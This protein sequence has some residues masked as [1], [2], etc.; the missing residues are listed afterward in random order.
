MVR[1]SSLRHRGQAKL[2]CHLLA[3][4]VLFSAGS[5]WT[6][7]KGS[8]AA[9]RAALEALYNAT[10]GA[11]WTDQTNWLSEE[12]L[13][14]WHGVSLSDDG[15]VI[16]L[17]LA[18]NNLVGG[19]PAALGNLSKL[20]ALFLNANT[21]T[22][23]IPSELGDLSELRQLNLQRNA[24]TGGIPAELGNLSK[25][26][27]LQLAFNDL[28]GPIP[29]QLG[30]LGELIILTL[31]S[32]RLTGGIPATF[33]NL[34][35]LPRLSVAFNHGLTGPLPSEL[36][37]AQRLEFL[38]LHGT[39]VCLPTDPTARNWLSG[40]VVASSGLTC[41]SD[42]PEE[43]VIDVA[44]FY[45][46]QARSAAGGKS[47]IEAA[48]DLRL[49]EA[50]QA[51]E[52]SGVNQR[53]ALAVRE[54]V[55]YS[56]AGLPYE[57][58]KRLLDP[59]DGHMDGIY[60]ILDIAGVD[61]VHLIVSDGGVCGLAEPVPRAESAFSLSVVHCDSLVFAHEIGHSMGLSHDRYQECSLGDQRC[62]WNNHYPYSYGYVNQRAFEAGPPASA[63]WH[64]IMAYRT[65]CGR[66]SISPCP[67]LAFFSNP[68]L[69]HQGDPMGKAGEH[70]VPGTD[71]PANAALALS[72][73][74]HSVA[75]FRAAV[76]P[77][78]DQSPAPVGALAM[79]TLAVGDAAVVLE[80]SGAFMDPNN[81]ALTYEAFSSDGDVAAV[82]LS[83]AV[84]TV[85][86]VSA[87]RSTITV[88]ATDAAG[89][90]T[91]AWQ[92]FTVFVNPED[93][94]DYDV[95]D[96]GLIEIATLA[97]LDAVRYDPN[98]IGES[99]ANEFEDQYA[100]AFPQRLFGM[101]CGT[102][103][104]LGYELDA[105]LD[106]DT[107][108][109]GGADSGD[110]FWNGGKGWRPL[111]EYR[112][113]TG[114]G[115]YRVPFDA[116]FEGN[117]HR[118]RN[119]HL[120]GAPNAS[121]IGLFGEVG[122][123]AVIRRVRMIDVDV[124]GRWEVGGLVGNNRGRIVAS[125]ATGSVTA[126][127]SIVGGLVGINLDTIV[128]SWAAV[129]VSG[130]QAVGGL[131]GVNFG[132][133]ER[134]F[135]GG[136]VAGQDGQVGGLVGK[137]Q[138]SVKVSYATGHIGEGQSR[139]GL[140]GM[141]LDIND[142]GE[143]VASYAAARVAGGSALAGGLIGVP[144]IDV[145]FSQGRVLASYWDTA[146]SGRET[147]GIGEGQAMKALQAPTRYT[148]IY[149]NWNLDLDGDGAA[150]DPWDF[151]TASQYP[152]LKADVDGDGTATWQEFGYQLR[153]GPAL[154]AV[155]GEEQAALRWTA[156]DAS[157]WLPAPSVTYRVTRA[158][159]A[160]VEV[161]ADHLDATEHTDANVPPGTYGYQVVALVEG[162][163]A[164]RSALVGN[165]V[166]RRL[167]EPD[168]VPSVADPDNVFR[169]HVAYPGVPFSL[170]LPEAS[171]GDNPAGTSYGYV[172]WHRNQ[173][174]QFNNTINGLTFTP[175]TRVLSGTP[176][177]PGTWEFHYEVHDG[178]ANRTAG[179]RFL[180]GAPFQ[181]TVVEDDGGGGGGGQLGE[182]RVHGGMAA[183]G[184][185]VRFLVTLREPM[186]RRV[187]LLADTTELTAEDGF[188]YHG[189][190][191]H[192]F[193][194]PAGESL[195]ALEVETIRD[196]DDGEGEE[197][198]E[199][200]LSL[201]DTGARVSL[202]RPR[203]RGTI[204]D[205]PLP[206]AEVPLFLGSEWEGGESFLRVVRQ[207]AGGGESVAVEAR[208]DAG[209]VRGPVLLALA[210]GAV[211]HFNT[212][213]LERGNAAKGLGPG[214]GSGE[215][216]WRLRL[217]GA[218]LEALSYL[219][220][221]SGFVTGLNG[222][223]PRGADDRRFVP[224]LN[225]ASNWRQVGL[226]WLSNP[227][228]GAAAV[229]V[230]GIDDAGASPGG[231]VR[232]S[233]A[234]GTSRTLTAAELESGGAPGLVEA[235]GDGSGKWRLLVSSDVPVEAMGL[236]RM[237]LPSGRFLG[238]LSVVPEGEMLP[239]GAV[240]FRVPLLPSA[241]DP[242]GRRGF[243]RVVNRGTAPAEALLRGWD[244]TPYGRAPVR[245]SVPASAVVH[246]NAY[247][248]E[249]GNADK[250]LPEGLGPAEGPWRIEVEGPPAL[251]VLAYVRD[252]DGFV[253]ELNTRAPLDAEGAHLVAFL[254]P[255]SN[256]RQASRLRLA[257]F[258]DGPARIRIQGIDDAGAS[259]AS[260]VA[261]TLPAHSA[262][263]LAAAELEA[264]GAGFEGSLGDGSG[265][266]RL[267]VRSDVPVEVMSL[268]ESP[269]GHLSN[270][271]AQFPAPPEAPPAEDG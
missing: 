179:D 101:G 224:I 126:R 169:N 163:E 158:G 246:L 195:V 261:L 65:Q 156:V 115:R 138:R 196:L 77:D 127:G 262:R 130:K 257:N 119:L 56:E 146:V 114:V 69:D 148:G 123:E 73:T 54:E 78:P 231:P 79:R 24:L 193:S 161:V 162:Q 116:V 223:A 228:P 18:F 182:V 58:F 270:L 55:P 131:V 104:C 15:R 111:G 100:A 71:G 212:G 137:N 174:A 268:L 265:K 251:L 170:T 1:P 140:L 81:D 255:G 227:G 57:D 217:E 235:L 218:G 243:L 187:D 23:E 263:E 252:P 122:S 201:A 82:S 52:N 112:N 51:F 3:L 184:D 31:E 133:V 164:T 90:N 121:G 26:I 189:L 207:G 60:A 256:W 172:L 198:F 244:D 106:F 50:N 93:A 62:H 208:D 220:S 96:D 192:V 109:S 178:D 38:D 186:G 63:G 75:G 238:N 205:G 36:R 117:G 136:R 97:Q 185:P 13:S 232:L 173:G 129:Q 124:T 247:D 157:H 113:W 176:T 166:V 203:A 125:S 33:G 22:G 188:D 241:S 43:V 4:G 8:P 92:Q 153:E 85:T 41:G 248:L 239:E 197:A 30:S 12:P 76:A 245:L 68:N 19:L 259:P 139:G 236:M 253:G 260:E 250:G 102:D 151:G 59:A 5:A 27:D 160:E 42:A 107:N 72:Q 135:A 105:D 21:L 266:W 199:V 87:G 154:V 61:L 34:S 80:V 206:S 183:E 86:P 155:G 95:D 242:K 16:Y 234:A 84:A 110:D 66:A 233:L 237:E 215:G 89:S 150:D 70:E 91:A 159:G 45:T 269:T 120:V 10:N 48:I 168:R 221:R 53:L 132:N 118:I 167:G 142:R 258:G 141:H 64:T 83:G 249:S 2:T 103:P 29:T 211:A 181:L 6:Q 108:R 202:V 98:G 177:V 210:P 209:T 20:R 213:D 152:A 14:T 254:N 47:W 240:R 39:T 134:S 128:D 145:D 165:V 264:G 222:L 37:N 230:E 219:R 180:Q 67:R 144:G 190:I 17:Q 194:I 226:L 271:S 200:E 204:A 35:G 11:D 40:V 99:V 32:N 44:V 171:G 88:T 191:G 143:V 9:D 216:G 49:T 267:R 147:G 25:L 7:A 94:V 149:G 74:R 46:P 229:A 175:A 28:S 225:P 214:T